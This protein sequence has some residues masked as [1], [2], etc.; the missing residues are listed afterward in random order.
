MTGLDPAGGPRG[1]WRKVLYDNAGFPDNFTPPECFLAARTF[2]QNL[3]LYT[4]AQCLAGAA[5]VG[6]QISDVIIFWC[7]YNYIKAG[8]ISPATLL[9]TTF[10]ISLLGFLLIVLL[11][12]AGVRKHAWPAIKTT[13]LFVMTGYALSPILHNLTESISTDSIHSM[14]ASS[15]LLHVVSADYG[16]TAP[17]TSWQISLNAS[18]FS[19]V[20]LASRLDSHTQ[21]FSLLSLS[22]FVFLLLPTTRPLLLPTIP[23]TV[24]TSSTSLYLLSTVSIPHTWLALTVLLVVEVLCPLLFH[25]LQSDKLTIH[26]P[27]DEAVP[28][29]S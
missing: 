28:A 26:G 3:V 6:T 22:V 12:N 4:R 23:W 21:A 11:V 17:L 2:N 20:C 19:S 15:F 9:L 14:A 18:V 24:I 8:D 7:C 27:W 25:H 13:F 5:R 10:T 16:V 29:H 1:P